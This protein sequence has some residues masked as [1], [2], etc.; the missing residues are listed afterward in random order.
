MTARTPRARWRFSRKRVSGKPGAV[1]P[2]L[3]VYERAEGKRKGE[4]DNHAHRPQELAALVEHALLDDLVRSPQ[5]RWR[6]RQ[7]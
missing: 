2:R 5:H 1:H 6:D 7:A 3:P 4:R